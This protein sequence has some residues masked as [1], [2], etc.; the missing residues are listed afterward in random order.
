[1]SIPD[2]KTLQWP[3]LLDIFRQ[4]KRDFVGKDVQ[5]NTT[6]SYV[7]SADQAGHFMLGFVPTFVIHWIGVAL[8]QQFGVDS[9]FGSEAN[10]ILWSA[11]LVMACWT[12]LELYDLYDSWRMARQGSGYFSFN[13]G[14]L[15]WNVATALIY[16]AFGAVIAAL[17]AWE[18]AV[19][20]AGLAILLVLQFFL[21]GVW[22]VRRKII[23]QQAGLPYLYRIANFSSTIDAPDD[24]RRQDLVDFITGLAGPPPSTDATQNVGDKFPRRHLVITGSQGSGKSSLAAGIGTE[25]AFNGGI[26]RY[27]TMSQLAQYVRNQTNLVPKL[28]APNQRALPREDEQEFN[29][30]RILWQWPSVDLLIIDDIIELLFPLRRRFEERV[31]SEEFQS[32][33]RGRLDDDGKLKQLVGDESVRAAVVSHIAECLQTEILGV[34]KPET[35]ARFLVEEYRDVLEAVEK[36]PHVIWV[37]GDTIRTDLFV[38][39]VRDRFKFRPDDPDLTVVHVRPQTP[40]SV[41]KRMY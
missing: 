39:F 15:V 21:V 36:I 27:T 7:W 26:A 8:K 32:E 40:Q 38:E 9:W 4:S 22:W 28:R 37:V 19:V 33:I 18:A 2:R 5:Q 20:L 10:G 17:S 24:K 16:F 23:F 6:Y 14:N 29:D 30:G 41:H 25:F 11:G 13:L 31:Q 1:M 12:G 35:F 3:S 34:A